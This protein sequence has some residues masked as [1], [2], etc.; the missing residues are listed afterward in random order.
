M[1]NEHIKKFL[2]EYLA[3]PIN[4]YAVLI[5]GSIDCGDLLYFATMCS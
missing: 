3:K 4:D 1:S 2:E 5:T